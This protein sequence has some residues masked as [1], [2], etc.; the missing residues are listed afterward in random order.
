MRLRIADPDVEKPEDWDEFAPYHIPDPM[1]KMPKDWD[2]SAPRF[3]PDETAAPPP[4]WDVKEDG[5]WTPPE[6]G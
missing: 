4:E 5:E 6:I 2:E 3:I 1:D